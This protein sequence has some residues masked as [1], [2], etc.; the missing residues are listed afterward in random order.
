MCNY[1]DGECGPLFFSQSESILT[2]SGRMTWML[3]T[4]RGL[5]EKKKKIC[6]HNLFFWETFRPPL[7]LNW[8]TTSLQ[9]SQRSRSFFFF[10]FFFDNITWSISAHWVGIVN[11][12]MSFFFPEYFNG[13]MLRWNCV[14][15]CCFKVKKRRFKASGNLRFWEMRPY[16]S[17][18]TVIPRV[19]SWNRLQ[20]WVSLYKCSY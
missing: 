8:Q 1:G 18:K 12:K 19:A 2:V 11:V 16:G 7:S 3:F 4:V 20:K 6:F 10:L 9:V 13:F 5:F 15:A 17:A 14:V